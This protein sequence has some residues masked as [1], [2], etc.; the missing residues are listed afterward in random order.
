MSRWSSLTSRSWEDPYDRHVQSLMEAM[1]SA[2]E[3]TQAA[4]ARPR[5]T[6]AG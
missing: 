1:G 2:S 4:G 6:R 3:G 5:P